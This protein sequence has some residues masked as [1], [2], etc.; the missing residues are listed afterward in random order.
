MK[1]PT[2]QELQTA[3]ARLSL[4]TFFPATGAEGLVYELARFVPHSQALDYICDLLLNQI[5]KWPDRGIAEIRGLLSLKY[6]PADGIESY[7]TLS[8]FTAADMEQRSI[9]AHGLLKSG[10]VTDQKLLQEMGFDPT[11]NALVR[12]SN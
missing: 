4:L 1:K 9:E 2:A 10:S 5:G 3:V 6:R 11:T 8:G 12:K 7:C